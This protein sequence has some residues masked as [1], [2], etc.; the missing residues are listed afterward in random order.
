LE[1]I[2]D[3]L[4]KIVRPPRVF[5]VVTISDNTNNFGLNGVILMDRNGEVW[6]IAV[7]QPETY[8]GMKIG[9]TVS[10]PFGNDDEL[11]WELVGGEIPQRLTDA[12]PAL[13]K[14]VWEV[15]S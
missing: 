7:Y 6:Q 2:I 3:D 1:N 4:L 8:H 9:E 13:V 14:E 15:T 10:V 5:K 11:A 12:P